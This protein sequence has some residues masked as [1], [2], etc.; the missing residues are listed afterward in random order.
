MWAINLM[1][2]GWTRYKI[3]FALAPIAHGVRGRMIEWL[4]KHQLCTH[5]AEVGGNF[6]Y[7]VILVA[8]SSAQVQEVLSD[9]SKRFGEVWFRK[10]VTQRTR[11]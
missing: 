5:V 10:A 1:A 11:A 7:E 2:C 9:L 8:K 6:D 4:V 3:F